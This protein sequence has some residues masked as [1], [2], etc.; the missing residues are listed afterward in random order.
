MC[1][2]QSCSVGAPRTL[3]VPDVQL[4][5]VVDAWAEFGRGYLWASGKR[6][7]SVV[8]V[9]GQWQGLRRLM[10]SAVE[11][12]QCV[13]KCCFVLTL[14]LGALMSWIVEVW[15]N[16]LNVE[17]VAQGSCGSLRPHR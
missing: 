16:V 14:P 2:L 8:R 9:D 11:Q 10:V 1:H 3:R 15:C 5:C 7:L 17:A 13:R 6:R 12:V 4:R